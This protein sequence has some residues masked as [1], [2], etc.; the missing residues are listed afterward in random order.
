MF[1]CIW[2]FY[3]RKCRCFDQMIQPHYAT[4][5]EK[6]GQ[7]PF[8]ILRSPLFGQKTNDYRNDDRD[9]PPGLPVAV[10]PFHMVVN[11]SWVDR[12]T[13]QTG[14]VEASYLELFRKIEYVIVDGSGVVA[15]VSGDVV[16]LE[17][18]AT[19]QGSDISITAEGR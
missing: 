10:L 15:V 8:R 11:S 3:N 17:S 9:I 14:S 6:V 13:Q 4:G 7:R 16:N 12:P 19:V 5:R 2:V 1:D 18:A